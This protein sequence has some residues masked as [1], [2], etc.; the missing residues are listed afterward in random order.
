[1]LDTFGEK[2]EFG[3]KN[4][5]LRIF[6]IK[7]YRTLKRNTLPRYDPRWAKTIFNYISRRVEHDRSSLKF[8]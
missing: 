5:F 6:K 3:R 8:L 7:K 4:L 1:M 2:F